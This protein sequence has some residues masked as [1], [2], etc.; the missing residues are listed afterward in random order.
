MSMRLLRRKN[1]EREKKK[2]A[3]Y[4]GEDAEVVRNAKL[5]VPV[6]WVDPILYRAR[7]TT[8]CAIFEGP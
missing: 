8:C 3:E 7:K 1:G 6:R 2:E 5:I 4:D